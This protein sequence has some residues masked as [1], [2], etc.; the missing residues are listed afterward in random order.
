MKPKQRVPALRG[1]EPGDLAANRGACDRIS[2]RV[3]SM[4]RKIAPNNSG[5]WG[6]S[7]LIFSMDA[8]ISRMIGYSGS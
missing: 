4:R 2:L 8:G 6:M 7:D 5:I 1:G 3:G